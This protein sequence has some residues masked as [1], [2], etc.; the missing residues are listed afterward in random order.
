MIIDDYLKST[1]PEIRGAELGGLLL[2]KYNNGSVHYI[3]EY[4]ASQN[5]YYQA[6][7]DFNAEFFMIQEISFTPINS[8]TIKKPTAPK[9]SKFDPSKDKGST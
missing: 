3:I 6:V 9:P 8:P 5:R 2:R 7:I 4:T 1:R